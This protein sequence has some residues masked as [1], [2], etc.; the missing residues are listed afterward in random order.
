MEQIVRSRYM[1]AFPVALLIQGTCAGKKELAETDC[2]VANS[3]W[4]GEH[5]SPQ[6]IE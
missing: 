4:V 2:F 1:P 5:G 3:Q 6:N